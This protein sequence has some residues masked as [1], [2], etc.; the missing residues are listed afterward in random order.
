[1][2]VEI[3]QNNKK[4]ILFF[5]IFISSLSF[6]NT[7]SKGLVNGCDFQWQPAVLLWDGINHYQKFIINGKGDFL[8]QNGEYAHLLHVLYYPFTL[9]DWETA[10]LLWLIVNIIF[11]FLIPLLICKS[12]KLSFNKSLILLLIFLTLFNLNL[13]FSG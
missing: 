3:F 12:F 11:I 4:K 1:M 6:Y 10:R 5:L 2:T 9:F 8:C 13:L 7:I